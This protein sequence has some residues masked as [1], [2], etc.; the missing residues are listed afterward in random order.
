MPIGESPW[1]LH[2]YYQ[3][4]VYN[5]LNVNARLILWLVLPYLQV[6]GPTIGWNL[7]L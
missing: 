6:C 3:T 4:Y 7:V 2:G 1:Q 5:N